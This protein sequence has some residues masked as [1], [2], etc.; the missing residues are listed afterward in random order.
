MK[1][2]QHEEFQTTDTDPVCTWAGILGRT[3]AKPPDQ[4]HYTR[5]DVQSK[6]VARVFLRSQGKLICVESFRHK[7]SFL[8][9]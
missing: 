5:E 2:S 3:E 1:R 4:K 9:D 6:Q 7:Q 8:W